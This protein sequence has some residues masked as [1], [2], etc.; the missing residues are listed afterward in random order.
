MNTTDRF[1][2]LGG[3]IEVG[4]NYTSLFFDRY[5]MDIPNHYFNSMYKDYQETLDYYL[6]L[7]PKI[8]DKGSVELP[9]DIKFQWI[10]PDDPMTELTAYSQELGLYE[11]NIAAKDVTDQVVFVEGSVSDLEVLIQK[12]CTS[13]EL[14]EEFTNIYKSLDKISEGINLKGEEQ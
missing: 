11:D 10:H 1:I 14:A 2:S 7:M 13:C 3:R 12:Y 5:K 9:V 4:I 8:R 6:D